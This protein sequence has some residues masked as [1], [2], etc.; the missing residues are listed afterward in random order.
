[1]FK[2]GDKVV[3]KIIGIEDERN[4]ISLSVKAIVAPEAY[5][6]DLK[7]AEERAARKAAAAATTEE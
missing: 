6:A 7:A 1:M 5:E 2:I 3:A 4:R